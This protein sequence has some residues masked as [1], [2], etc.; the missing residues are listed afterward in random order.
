MACRMLLGH[1]GRCGGMHDFMWTYRMLCWHVAVVL[2]CRM[3]WGRVAIDILFFF[4]AEA[5][6]C[7]TMYGEVEQDIIV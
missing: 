6:P 2:A 5:D 7:F 1:V 3:L 4:N